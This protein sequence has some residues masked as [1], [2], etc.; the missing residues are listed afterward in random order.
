MFFNMLVFCLKGYPETLSHYFQKG[1]QPTLVA[2]RV[3]FDYTDHSLS[4]L[5]EQFWNSAALGIRRFEFQ[6]NSDGN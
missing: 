2:L 5:H 3:P 6:T 1:P 4:V